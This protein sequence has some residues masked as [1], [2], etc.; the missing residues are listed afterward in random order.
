MLHGHNFIGV[1]HVWTTCP[2]SRSCD[3]AAGSRTF[4]LSIASP[5]RYLFLLRVLLPHKI[6]FIDTAIILTVMCK[7]SIWHDL[8]SSYSC[9][10]VAYC[11]S[12]NARW[13]MQLVNV[14]RDKAE[15]HDTQVRNTTTTTTA[16]H[17][18]AV[19]VTRWKQSD[20]FTWLETSDLNHLKDW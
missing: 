16:T 4:D 19:D 5:S 20:V 3:A 1:G 11:K 15:G 2:G 17:E 8:V 10:T 7:N 14:V 13:W 12:S 6:F 9:R 18:R